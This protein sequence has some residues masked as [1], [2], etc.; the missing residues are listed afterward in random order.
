VAK[1][2]ADAKEARKDDDRHRA[3]GLHHARDD[4]AEKEFGRN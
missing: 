4:K 1:A 3:E 2:E